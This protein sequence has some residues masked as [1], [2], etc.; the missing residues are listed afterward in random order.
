M[1]TDRRVLGL[2][3]RARRLVVPLLVIA[4]AVILVGQLARSAR[5]E[6][7]DELS[8]GPRVGGDL[9]AVADIEDRIY[10]GGHG[11]AAAWDAED[12]WNQIRSLDDKDVMAWAATTSRVLAGGHSGLYRS[13]DGGAT[14]ATVDGMGG[15]DVHAVGASGGRVYLASPTGGVLVSE[16]G[17]GSFEPRSE[18]GSAF[19]GSI[20]VD[21][22]N[23]DVAIAPS[24]QDG[25]MRTTDGGRSW[26]SLGGPAGVMS[27]GASASGEKL[28][29]VGMGVTQESTD[30][31]K[32]WMTLTVPPRTA[33]ATYTSKGALLAAVLTGDRASVSRKTDDGWAVVR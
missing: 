20:W 33:A 24:M 22:R 14:F 32:S 17:G 30:G 28:V 5:G 12:G 7:T 10:V 21:P 1:S 9:H 26:T 25:V 2:S 15:V 18:A 23:P 31:G 16:D 3:R 11:G 4:A 27:L 29:A 8:S 13:D 6:G 19:M